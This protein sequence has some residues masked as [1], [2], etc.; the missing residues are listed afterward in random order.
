MERVALTDGTVLT[1]YTTPILYKRMAPAAASSMTVALAPPVQLPEQPPTLFR[2]QAQPCLHPTLPM[3][4]PSH[5]R[6]P[7]LLQLPCACRTTLLVADIDRSLALYRDALGLVVC[8]DNMVPIGGQGLPTG[9]FDAQANPDLII[10]LTLIAL[11]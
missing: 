11:H 2:R 1:P 8:F 3:E 6:T 10:T 5:T 9:V 7:P 4:L